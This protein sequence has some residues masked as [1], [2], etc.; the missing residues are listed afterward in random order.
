MVVPS[1]LVLV[2]L[3]VSILMALKDLF[4]SRVQI[5]TLNRDEATHFSVRKG[6]ELD[7][8]I[9]ITGLCSKYKVVFCQGESLTAFKGP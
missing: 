8:K 7:D 4:L 1:L 9:Q 3:Y 2:R 5:T 6:C